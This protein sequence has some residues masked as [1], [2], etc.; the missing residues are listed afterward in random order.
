MKHL[1][2]TSETLETDSCNMRFQAQ[3]LHAAWMK[4]EARNA[5]LD[6]DVEF[7]ATEWRGGRRCG[8]RRRHGPR[9]GLWQADGAR[10]Q[11]ET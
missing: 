9:Q 7:D 1:Q 11:Q 5:E 2:H 4:M 6:A 8:T 3:Y 10:P